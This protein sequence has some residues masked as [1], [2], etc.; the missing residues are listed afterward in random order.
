[1]MLACYQQEVQPSEIYTIALKQLACKSISS[2]ISIENNQTIF[3]P[4][5]FSTNS[6]KKHKTI[7]IN[8][9]APIQLFNI[10]MND[11]TRS[12]DQSIGGKRN[13]SVEGVYIPQDVFYLSNL[14]QHTRNDYEY[15]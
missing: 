10:L 7:E 1:M 5:E 11:V 13:I 4:L 6:L 3:A 14:N 15:R 8:S 12:F 2:A 9:H